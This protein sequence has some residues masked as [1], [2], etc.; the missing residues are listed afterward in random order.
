VI[1]TEPIYITTTDCAAFLASRGFKVSKTYFKKITS[2]SVG[3]GPQSAG[4][5]GN[6]KVFKPEELL[7]WAHGRIR[8]TRQETA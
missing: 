5:W 7:R 3:K 4:F 1:V 2:P 8:P 6:R